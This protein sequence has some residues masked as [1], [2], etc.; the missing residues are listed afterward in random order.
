M[1]NPPIHGRKLREAREAQE[2]SLRDVCEAV[3]ALTPPGELSERGRFDSRNL[4]QYERGDHSPSPQRLALLCQVLGLDP[5]A[6]RAG[7]DLA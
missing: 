7:G 4:S 2:L 6:V 5:A 3:D 1:S